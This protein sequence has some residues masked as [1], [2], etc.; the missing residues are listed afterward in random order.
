MTNTLRAALPG[1][2][3]EYAPEP[4]ARPDWRAFIDAETP[5]LTRMSAAERDRWLDDGAQF[6]LIEFEESEPDAYW[7]WYPRYFPERARKYAAEIGRKL[8]KRVATPKPPSSR[9]K[10][11]GDKR[12]L[13]WRW[14]PLPIAILADPKLSGN[15]V[16]VAAAIAH[17]IPLG[18]KNVELSIDLTYAELARRAKVGS[19]K[20][21]ARAVAELV[22][23]DAETGTAYLEATPLGRGGNRFRFGARCRD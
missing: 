4:T 18:E 8:P 5:K 13:Y 6:L 2:R 21:A 1:L 17:A 14:A 3:G 20:T 16:L 10:R 19:Y 7:E 11:A 15:A 9:G 23:P 12:R 22:K